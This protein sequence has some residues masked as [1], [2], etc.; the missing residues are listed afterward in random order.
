MNFFIVLFEVLV[1]TEAAAK[2]NVE[3]LGK[4]KFFYAAFLVGGCVGGGGWGNCGNLRNCFDIVCGS[5]SFT[6]GIKFAPILELKSPRDRKY[7][8]QVWRSF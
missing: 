5:R 3:R 4:K 7:I 8:F 1:S 6:V 2:N